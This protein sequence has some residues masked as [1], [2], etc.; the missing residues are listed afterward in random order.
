MNTITEWLVEQGIAENGFAAG[1]IAKGL[2]LYEVDPDTKQPLSREEQEARC[3]RYRMWR[4]IGSKELKPKHAYDLAIYGLEPNDI[5]PRQIEMPMA[6][7][8]EK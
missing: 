6:E 4:P 2:K 1:H 5:E 3:R 8:E 7:S